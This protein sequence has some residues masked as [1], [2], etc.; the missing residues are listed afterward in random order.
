MSTL[1]LPRT[2]FSAD[3]A[4]RLL[5]LMLVAWQPFVGG[6]RLPSILLLIVGLWMIWQ[7]RIDWSAQN[8]KR[9]GLVFLA[10]GIPVLLSAPHSYHPPASINVAVALVLFYVAGLALL[11][12]LAQDEDHVWLQRWLLITVVAWLLDG[13]IQYFFGRDLLGIAMSEEGRV[14]GPFEGNLRFGLFITILMPVIFW[15]LLPER[16]WLGLALIG[17]LGIMAG[18]SGARS[19]VLFYLLSCFL[20]W[21]RFDLR[22]RVVMII[23]VIAAVYSVFALSPSLSERLGRSERLLLADRSWFENWDAMLSGRLMIWE[24]AWNMLADRPLTGVGAGAFAEAYDH[25]STRA[26]DPFVTGGSYGSPSHAHQMYV[27]MAAESGWPG[28]VSLVFVVG[29]FTSWYLRAQTEQRRQAAPYA[30]SLAVIAFPLQSQPVLYTIW[31]FPVVLLLICCML[32]ALQI[33]PAT[34]Q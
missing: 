11:Q 22:R 33:R 7:R 4:A 12:G 34:G 14:L 28:L 16:P 32:S 19:N 18:M 21:F 23:T 31:W 6:P 20:L 8:V 26:D 2:V 25:Y 17:M 3:A 5:G 30:A 15:R 10:L 13:Y 9:L 1:S 27:S 29:L 24:T